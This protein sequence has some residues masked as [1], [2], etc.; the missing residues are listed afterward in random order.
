VQPTG[1]HLQV[2]VSFANLLMGQAQ[3]AAPAPTHNKEGLL[4]LPTLHGF[5]TGSKHVQAKRPS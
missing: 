5:L 1:D 2:S 4:K 3:I